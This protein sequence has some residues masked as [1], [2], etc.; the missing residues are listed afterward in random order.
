MSAPCPRSVVF[1]DSGCLGVADAIG[2]RG[3]LPAEA[4]DAVRHASRH[5]APDAD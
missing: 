3:T 1:R 4:L 5:S 2:P